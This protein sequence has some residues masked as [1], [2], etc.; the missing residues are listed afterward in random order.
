MSPYTLSRRD[1]LKLGAVCAYSPFGIV[2]CGDSDA[3][4]SYNATIADARSAILKALTDSGT[5]SISVA[6][7][8]RN[9]VIWSE[10]FGVIDKATN[11][12]PTTVTLPH[13][14]PRA[15][16]LTS[17]SGT[18]GSDL[19]LTKSGGSGTGAVSYA[20]TTAGTAGCSLATS[21]TLAATSA[22]TCTVTVTKAADTNYL[23]ASSSATTVTF[24]Q[25]AQAALTLTS[26]SGT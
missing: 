12:A 18:Y 1:W 19:T 26:T 24:A 25:A 15:L 22:G 7:I 2:G 9:R 5:P 17:T 3:P 11:A 20:V 6:L 8:E 10:A 13:A 23:V 4:L 21:T 14:R 16:T